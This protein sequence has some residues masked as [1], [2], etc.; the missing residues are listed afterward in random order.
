MKTCNP[1]YAKQIPDLIWRATGARPARLIPIPTVPDAIVYEAQLPVG[2]VIIFK[3]ID[4]EGRDPDGIGLE[5]WMCEQVCALGVPA[6][7]VLTV[8]ISHSLLPTPYFVMEKAHGQP[9]NS[10]PAAQQPAVLRQ[11]GAYLRQIHSMQVE[12]F[13]WLDEQHYRQYRAVQGSHTSWRAAVVKDI[14]ASLAYFEATNVLEPWALR[15]IERVRALADP[16]LQRVTDGRLLHGDLGSLHV[17]VDPEHSTVTS[18]VDFGER[19][20][21]DPIW[22]IMRFE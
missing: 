11:I 5:A 9:L 13:G 20:V 7:Q 6:P 3:A 2:A 17:W 10:L 14:A 1:R 21:G 16:M 12:R 22:D 4:P 18:F 15:A 8:D 19:S